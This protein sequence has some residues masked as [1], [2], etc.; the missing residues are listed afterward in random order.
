M[1]RVLVVDDEDLILNMVKEAI[2]KMGF[3]AITAKSATEALSIFHDERPGTVITDLNLGGDMD[4]VS[5]CSRIRYEDKSVVVVA[6]SGYFSE[7][8][9]IYCLEAGFSDFLSKPV[10]L[11][12]LFS[13]VQCAFDR[14][15]RWMNII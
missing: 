13:A 6:M 4:G 3:R 5:L 10:Q 12:A 7:Y 15:S 1:N 11:D 9:K 14:R 2:E 8:D